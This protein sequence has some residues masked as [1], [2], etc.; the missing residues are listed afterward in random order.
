MENFPKALFLTG[1]PG[2][3]K[4]TL[5]RKTVE[6]LNVKAGGFYTL[7]IREAGRRVGF[8]IVTLDGERAVLSHVRLSSNYRVGRYGVDV[9]ALERVGVAAIRVAIS[10]GTL[11][12]VD[13]IGKMELYS[14]AFRDAVREAL[15]QAEKVLGTILVASHPWADEVKDEPWVRLLKVSENN[16]AQIFQDIVNWLRK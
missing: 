1:R 4:T 8:E 2:S 16:R 10:S 5:I 3:G 14:R 13:E 15:D 6:S 11:V 9:E 12:V 7:E